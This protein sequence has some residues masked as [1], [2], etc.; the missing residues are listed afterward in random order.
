MVV[1]SGNCIWDGVC[2]LALRHSNLAFS[3]PRVVGI[4]SDYKR[5]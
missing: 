4:H 1:H 3:S 5:F 2:Y